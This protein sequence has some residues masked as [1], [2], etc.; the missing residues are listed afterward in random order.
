MHTSDSNLPPIQLE[1]S[2]TR[3]C[4]PLVPQVPGRVGMYVCGVTVYDHCH[5][6]HAVPAVVFDAIRRY[7]EYRGY[8]VDFVVNFTDV[9]DKIIN[10]AH[11]EGSDYLAVSER[12][13][14]SYFEDMDRLGVRRA[15][16]Y[17]RA[18][19]H[20]PEMHEMIRVLM[21]KGAAYAVEGDV[22]F[23]IARFAGYGK[24]SGRKVEELLAGARIAA[25]SRLRQPADFALWKGAKPGEP[26]WDSPWGRGRPGWHIECS[27]MACRYLGQTF[28]IHGGG[29]DLV[30]PHHENEIAQ[31]EAATGQPFARYWMH[32]GILNLG[33]QK[34]SKSIGNVLGLKLLFQKHSPDELRQYLLGTH[35]RSPQNF[36]EDGLEKAA[37]AHCRFTNVFERVTRVLAGAGKGAGGSEGQAALAQPLRKATDQAQG[38]FHQCMSDDFNT[39]GAL[40]ALFELAAELNRS[41]QSAETDGLSEGLAAPVRQ[42]RATLSELLGVLGFSTAPAAAPAA[43]RSSKL[44]GKLVELLVELRLDA[45]KAKDFALADTIRKRLSELGVELKDSPTGTTYSLKV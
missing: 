15:S 7:L 43:A 32:N 26:G 17:P 6:G 22:Y 36:E 35:Y 40:G 37:R 3:R 21:D 38:R 42:A 5:L 13:I 39:G 24:L 27:A 30:F 9:D 8:L 1:N 19:Q 12:F 44:T 14:A 34:M 18:T 20:I 10:R 25:D 29:L 11:A 2:L 4:E 31:S 28:D 41:L 45:R 16:L 33:G 23:D